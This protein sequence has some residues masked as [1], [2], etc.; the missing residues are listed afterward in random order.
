MAYSI[1]SQNAAYGY[2]ANF[3]PM[4]D[5]ADLT[6]GYQTVKSAAG[7]NLMAEVLAA[8]FAA[9][10]AMA[11]GALKELGAVIRQKGVNDT[12]LDIA[13]KNRESN[14]KANKLTALLSVIAPGAKTAFKSMSGIDALK[15]RA[16]SMTLTDNALTVDI[17]ALRNLTGLTPAKAA[18]DAVTGLKPTKT[19]NSTAGIVAIPTLQESPSISP[20]EKRFSGQQVLDF[21]TTIRRTASAQE[22]K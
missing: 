17:N 3:K 12:S 15:N 22:K 2:A 1:P 11:Q 9:K 5:A 14:K 4:F 20:V 6:S 8:D 13:N 21:L 18:S 7:T 10:T 19:K 16:D